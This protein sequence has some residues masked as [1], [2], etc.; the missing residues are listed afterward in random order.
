MD[1][2]II[3]LCPDRNIGGLRNSVGSIQHH[4]YDRDILGVVGEDA[5]PQEI[6][7]M[8]QICPIHKGENTI[9]SLINVGMKK[10]K[11][12]WG[13]IMFSGSRVPNYVEH[14]LI[15]F[16]K[17]D[18]EILFPVI[19]KKWSFVEGSFNGVLIN[20]KFFKKIGDFPCQTMQKQGMNDFELAKLFWAIDAIDQG[21][22]FRAIVG[23]RVI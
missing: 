3:I 17:S 10:N 18:N 5:S 13:F 14:K 22:K 4:M 9:T 16:C 7:E 1:I 6:K 19:D 21:C 11:H 15:A 23:M 8:K 20:T 12:D 2:G